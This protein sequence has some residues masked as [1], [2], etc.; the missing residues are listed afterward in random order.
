MIRKI[1]HTKRGHEIRDTIH[2]YNFVPER[3][4][5]LWNTDHLWEEHLMLDN[6]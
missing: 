2:V 5:E 1:A 4:C 6:P 3:E